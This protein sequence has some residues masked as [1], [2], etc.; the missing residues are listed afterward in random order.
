LG[1][2]RIKPPKARAA[3]KDSRMCDRSL[4]AGLGGGFIP[5]KARVALKV[6]PMGNRSLEAGLRG[7]ASPP[8]RPG[9]RSRTPEL[10]TG[11]LRP[12]LGGG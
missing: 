11:A 3:L 4:E 7:G 2:E 5:P 10:E 6:S 12:A 1:G 8:L 9:R